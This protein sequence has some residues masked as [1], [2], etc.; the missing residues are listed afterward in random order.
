[1]KATN[2]VKYYIVSSNRVSSGYGVVNLISKL[3]HLLD[4]PPVVTVPPFVYRAETH[5]DAWIGCS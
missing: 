4:L 1:M 2:R 3:A 5:A